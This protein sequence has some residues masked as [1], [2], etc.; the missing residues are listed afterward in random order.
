M[1]TTL[2]ELPAGFLAATARDLH[3]LLPG[4][5]LIHLPG[6]NLAPVF[7]SI[8]LHGNEDT[9]LRAVQRVLAEASSRG[10]PRALSVFVGNIQAAA[11]GLR[12]LDGQPDYNR[13]W[14]GTDDTADLPEHAMMRQV[15]EDMRARGVFASIDI[16]N[17]TGLNPHYACVNRLE[18]PFLHLATLF[19]RTVVWF[20]R[21]LGVQSQAFAAL[22]PAVTVECGKPGNP[23][24]EREAARLLEA[25]L[26]LDHLPLHPIPRHDIDLY[27]TVAMVKLADGVTC[28]FDGEPADLRFV[29]ELER[30]NFSELAP[31]TQ[32]AAVAAGR[33]EPLQVTDSSGAP[34]TARF[35]SLAGGAL[36][37]R[38]AV[39]PAMLTRDERV[40]RQDCLCYL[41]ERMP[42]RSSTRRG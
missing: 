12:R 15:V 36:R 20:E 2:S 23:G 35:F 25:V 14:P 32:I 41:M 21:P 16:H 13:V 7:A 34:A 40:I 31:G 38:T 19:S 17:N 22:C 42:L 28:S 26:H 10:L 4:P 8:L 30:M 5:T 37:T 27:H 1:L 18:P 29:P 9:G 3:R 39:M 33:S 6:R 11:L 24:G